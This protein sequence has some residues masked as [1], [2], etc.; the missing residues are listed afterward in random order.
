ME[1]IYRGVQ[2]VPLDSLHLS[3]LYHGQIGIGTIQR[4]VSNVMFKGELNSG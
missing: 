4:L 3:K 2:K 1:L